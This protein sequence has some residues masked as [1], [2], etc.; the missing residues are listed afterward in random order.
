M[1]MREI[2]LEPQ[3]QVGELSERGAQNRW[4]FLVGINQYRDQRFSRL[5]YCVNDVTVLK[6]VLEQVSYTVICLHDGDAIS[7]RDR[8]FPVRENIEHELKQ[9]CDQIEED[10]LLLVYFACHGAR[11][12]DHTPRLVTED[13]RATDIEARA[14]AISDLENWMRSSGAKR[15]VLMID[16]CHMGAGTDQ[17]VGGVDPE[18]V[19]NVYE[20]AEGFAFLAASTAAQTARELGG[21]QHGLFSYYILQGLAGAAVQPE[22]EMVTVGSLQR[23]VL[24]EMRKQGVSDGINQQPMGRADGNLGDM[25]LVDLRKGDSEGVRSLFPEQHELQETALAGSYSDKAGRLRKEIELLQKKLER[26]FESRLTT[27][28]PVREVTLE[29]L[30]ENLERDIADKRR[31]LAELD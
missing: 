16:A 13:T 20:L 5:Q 25:V 6:R 30:E 18:F 31:Q 7:P 17:R 12:G 21:M 15:L 24:N 4:A 28:D 9:L 3:A 2:A 22:L 29:R 26:C 10:D 23:Y 8:L 27:D 1:N 14:I 11:Q 19:R